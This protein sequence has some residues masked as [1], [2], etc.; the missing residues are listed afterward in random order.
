MVDCMPSSYPIMF[1]GV[2]ESFLDLSI[3][4]SANDGIIFSVKVQF[5]W[6]IVT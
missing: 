2:E 6:S 5:D 3:A 1:D 4:F